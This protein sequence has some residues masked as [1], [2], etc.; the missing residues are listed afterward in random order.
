[1]GKSSSSSQA[2]Q[3]TQNID[4]RVVNDS[5][6][7]ARDSV[8]NVSSVDPEIAKAAFD[9]ATKADATNG[10]GFDKLLGA[11]VELTKHSQDTANGLA[12]KFQDNVLQAFDSARNTTPGGIDNKTMIV[13]AVAA[14]GALAVAASNRR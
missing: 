1:M 11:A 4:D 9:F 2:N 12:A 14:A 6:V 10:D 3:T 5:G 13:I 7:V 8:V